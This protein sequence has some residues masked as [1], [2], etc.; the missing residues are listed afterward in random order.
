MKSADLNDRQW[1]PTPSELILMS[2]EGLA[3]LAQFLLCFLFFNSLGFT[4]LLILGGGFFLLSMVLGWRAR[5][6][7]EA[8]GEAPEGDSWLHTR[9]VV[10]TNVYGLVR[11]P[12]YLSFLLI[13]LTLVCLSQH[14]MNALLGVVAMGLIINDMRSEEQSNLARF[15]D[16]YRRYVQK[17]PRMNLV[18]GWIRSMRRK[19]NG[20]A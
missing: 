12:M 15:G 11:H 14:W 20:D 3:F 1:Q 9:K 6:A 4:W 17:V 18:L 5:L 7:F 2:I 16:D 10:E 8:R 13:S 19:R